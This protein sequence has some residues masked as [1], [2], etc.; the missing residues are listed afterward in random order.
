[1]IMRSL[2]NGKFTFINNGIEE[3][4]T[5]HLFTIDIEPYIFTNETLNFFA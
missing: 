2:G 3:G 1:M 5:T 4:E